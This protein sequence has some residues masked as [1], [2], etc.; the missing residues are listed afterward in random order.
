MTGLALKK[1]FNFGVLFEF[2]ITNNE[3]PTV[4][5]FKIYAGC[6]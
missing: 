3:K 4:K 2:L 5:L 6:G 1:E